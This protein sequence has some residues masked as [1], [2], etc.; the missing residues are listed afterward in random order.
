[1]AASIRAHIREKNRWMSKAMFTAN[2]E[3]VGRQMH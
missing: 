2:Q 3:S 1:M